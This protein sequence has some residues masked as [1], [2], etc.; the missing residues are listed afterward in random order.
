VSGGKGAHF[1]NRW[2]D[3]G[4]QSTAAG[5]ESFRKAGTLQ[6]QLPAGVRAENA[7]VPAARYRSEGIAA[8]IGSLPAKVDIITMSSVHTAGP[9]ECVAGVEGASRLLREGGLFVV[10][11]P[12]VSLGDEAGMDRIADR[13]ADLFG[14][15]V[16]SGEC[17]TLQQ[18]VD[19]SFPLERSAS[20]AIY[21]R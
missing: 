1:I 10:K 15:P 18:H 12:D 6:R 8:A 11:A 17:G 9:R 14:A 3:L 21:Q 5:M 19:P 16:A 13:A 2:I 20:F 7:R 4:L